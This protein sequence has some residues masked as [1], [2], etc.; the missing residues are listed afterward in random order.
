MEVYPLLNQVDSTK[1][2]NKQNYQRDEYSD[3]FNSYFDNYVEPMY[4]P[5]LRSLGACFG[6][7]CLPFCGCC[8]YPYKS[9]EMGSRA[10]IQEYGRVNR[11]VGEGLH[12]VNPITETLT[13]INM[14]VQVIDLSRQNVMTM[15]KVQINID[16]IV[17]FQI[18][19][20]YDAL[21]KIENIR[22]SIVELSYITLRTVIGKST[23]D[24]CLGQREKLAN[25]IKEIVD[26]NV[27]DW[28]I[29]IISLQIK[30][31]DVPKDIITSL[32]SAVTAE[33]E[34]KAKIITAKADVEAAKLMRD[35]ADILSTPAAMQ[36]RSLEV[37]DRLGHS[38]NAKIIFLPS[39]L[40]LT[41][42]IASNLAVHETV[43]V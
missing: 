4:V 13:S 43:I 38:S 14:K 19:N 3:P 7:M 27:H 39:D 21:F 17:Y 33:R 41:N 32:S 16:S 25:D 31:I 8:C 35:A 40:S 24:A 10:I 11:E 26:E 29:K 1:P 22:H 37:I 15:D 23:L 18:I 20:P 30:D 6:Y 42:S 2:P 36:I 34:A 28:G 9:V 5:F 12:Y